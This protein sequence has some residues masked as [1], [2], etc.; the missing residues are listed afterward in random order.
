MLYL[1]NVYPWFGLPKKI[2]TDRDPQFTS[3]FGKA[4]TTQIGAQQ[5]ISMAFHPQMDR[6]SEW[7]NQW[8][9]QYL[10]IVTSASP[11]DWMSWL[12]IT[13]AVH[14]NC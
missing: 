14:N 11:K 1:K 3:R 13:S 6:L 2:I 4:L 5:N 9:E 7:K 8:V 12:S 10:C